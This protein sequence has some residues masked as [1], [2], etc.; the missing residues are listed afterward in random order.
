MMYYR[1]LRINFRKEQL[2]LQNNEQKERT[3]FLH[4]FPI[5]TNFEKGQEK[6]QKEFLTYSKRSDIA[7]SKQT[8][9]EVSEKQNQERIKG[10][11]NDLKNI[12]MIQEMNAFRFF[13][14]FTF[15]IEIESL[16]AFLKVNNNNLHTK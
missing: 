13:K 12:Y 2:R 4:S 1:S 6:D 8:I 11:E 16:K 5:K 15:P 7:K 10:V 9:T 3:N 14:D